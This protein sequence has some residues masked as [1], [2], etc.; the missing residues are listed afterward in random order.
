MFCGSSP[1]CKNGFAFKFFCP[2]AAD[3]GKG[4]AGV[5]PSR[6][7]TLRKARALYDY[8]AKADDE[9]SIHEGDVIEIVEDD[10]QWAAGRLGDKSDA[11]F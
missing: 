4:K 8:E 3:A 2:S 6:P 7:T 11:N 1:C 5:Q 10:G 9:M